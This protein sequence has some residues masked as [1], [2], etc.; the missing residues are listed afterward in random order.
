MKNALLANRRL[1]LGSAL[2]FTVT[3]AASSFA[4]P[5]PQYWQQQDRLRAEHVAKATPL[6]PVATAPAKP[7]MACPHCKTKILEESSFTNVSGKIALRSTIIGRR[8]YCEGCSGFIT[9][10]RGKV[11]DEMKRNCPI[12]AKAGPTCCTTNV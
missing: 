2:A 10:A 6:T 3:F 7:A 4:G 1:G 12:C 11:T 8:H 5:G 9:L